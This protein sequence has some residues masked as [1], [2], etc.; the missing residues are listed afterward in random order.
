MNNGE[1]ERNED[2]YKK[3]I[4][5]LVEDCNNERHLLLIYAYIDRLT[6]NKKD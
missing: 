4:S 1:K 2:F 3:Q 5:K 6:R